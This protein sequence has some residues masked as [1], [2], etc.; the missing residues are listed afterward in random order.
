MTV[1]K[2]F[3]AD[4]MRKHRYEIEI[5]RRRMKHRVPPALPVPSDPPTEILHSP[6]LRT[7]ATA[8]V[9]ADAI[10]AFDPSG[11]AVPLRPDPGFLEIGQGEWE[12]LTGA[13][14]TERYGDTLAAWRRRPWETVAPGGET[15]Q[16]VTGR[17]RPAR[18]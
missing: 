2:S 4:T 15:L 16:G 11:T 12:G 8:E 5:V 6:L 17:V 14:I 9:I 10:G 3:V 18:R 1:G 7:A 13:V